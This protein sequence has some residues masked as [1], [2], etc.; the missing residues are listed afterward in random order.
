ML[1]YIR[2]RNTAASVFE[3]FERL[4]WELRPDRFMNL[5]RILLGDY[6]EE[7]TMPKNFLNTYKH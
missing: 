4:Y 2:D 6:T 7:N 1:T 3:V 5:F